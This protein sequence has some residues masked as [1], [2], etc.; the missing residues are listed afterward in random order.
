M[1][2]KSKNTMP[3]L[4]TKQKKYIYIYMQKIICQQCSN[5]VIMCQVGFVFG[6]NCFVLWKMLLDKI[7]LASKVTREIIVVGRK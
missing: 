1:P 7:Y 6:S 3:Q 2:L 5:L 4:R